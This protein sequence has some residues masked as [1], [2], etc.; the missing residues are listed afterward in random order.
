MRRYFKVSEIKWDPERASGY[1]WNGPAFDSLP[2]TQNFLSIEECENIET[3]LKDTLLESYG[4]RVE[5]LTYIEM[6]KEEAD[7]EAMFLLLGAVF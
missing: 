3:A 7:R 6:T 4:Y 5:S 2:S 1:I